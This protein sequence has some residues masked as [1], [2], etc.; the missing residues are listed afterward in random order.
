MGDLVLRRVLPNMRVPGHGA[1]GANW[2]GPYLI[3][4]VIWEGTY[5]LIDLDGKLIPRAWNAEHLRK[6]Y[7]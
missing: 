3:K 4:T 1:F 7:Q 5:H 2:E 6:Y